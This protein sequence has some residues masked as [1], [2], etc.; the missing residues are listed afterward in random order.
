MNRGGKLK[1][2]KLK[3]WIISTRLSKKMQTTAICLFLVLGKSNCLFNLDCSAHCPESKQVSSRLGFRRDGPLLDIS[4]WNGYS[5]HSGFGCRFV[6]RI[7][8]D[9]YPQLSLAK[10]LTVCKIYLGRVGMAFDTKSN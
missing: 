5:I 1:Q 2:T 3:Y 6:T 10:C 9:S 8:H 4:K 7:E